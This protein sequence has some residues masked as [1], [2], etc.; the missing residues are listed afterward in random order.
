MR[1]DGM[2]TGGVVNIGRVASNPDTI[3]NNN[4]ES[5]LDKLKKTPIFEFANNF[6]P[7]R[8]DSKNSGSSAFQS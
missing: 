3:G 6:N 5:Y 2:Q 7:T 1:E 8:V 4:N